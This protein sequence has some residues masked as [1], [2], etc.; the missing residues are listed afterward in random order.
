MNKKELLKEKKELLKKIEVEGYGNCADEE[1]Y[2][3]DHD[4]IFAHNAVISGVE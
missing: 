2:R 4:C 3:C 1:D